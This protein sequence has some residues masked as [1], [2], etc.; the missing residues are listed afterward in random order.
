MSR[1]GGR[2][3]WV[4]VLAL[5]AACGGQSRTLSTDEHGGPPLTC[6]EGEPV[7]LPPEVVA[8]RLS[9]LFFDEP[10]DESLLESAGGRDLT[11]TGAVGCFARDM[12]DDERADLGISE[13]FSGWLDLAKRAEPLQDPTYVPEFSKELLTRAKDASLWYATDVVRAGKTF[14]NLLNDSSVPLDT[15]LAPLYGID[16]D[17]RE[18]FT[19]VEFGQERRGILTQLYFLMSRATVAHGSP[20]Q[21]GS[22]LLQMLGCF[23]LPLPPV[24][25]AAG[26]P[27]VFEGTTRAWYE[28]ALAESICQQCHTLVTSVGY[29]LEHY[30]VIG[31]YRDEEAGQPIDATSVFSEFGGVTVDGHVDAMRVLA[32]S[33]EAR[34]CF[35]SHWLAYALAS[36][37]GERTYAAGVTLDENA[38]SHVVARASKDPDF[39][40]REMFVAGVETAPFLVP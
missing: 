40:L 9:R 8:E 30:D 34:R 17:G 37:R 13:F 15:E 22:A 36:L 10:A 6:D 21:R 18:S 12:L 4:L 5:S 26:V 24:D 1:F 7:G 3:R 16:F 32:A 2:A 29:A 20:T 11:T 23:E 28:L 19:P 31:R 27:A 35:A 38:V 39:D 14:T 33:P 25:L